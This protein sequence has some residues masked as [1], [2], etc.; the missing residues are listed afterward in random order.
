MSIEGLRGA[1][2][3]EPLWVDDIVQAAREY[4]PRLVEALERAETGSAEQR[5][6]EDGVAAARRLARNR[7]GYLETSRGAMA[8][9]FYLPRALLVATGTKVPTGARRRP[10]FV[11]SK[12]LIVSM[13]DLA[14]HGS[15]CL[16][17]SPRRGGDVKVDVAVMKLDGAREVVTGRIFLRQNGVDEPFS[18]SA[19]GAKRVVYDPGTCGIARVAAQFLVDGV[20]WVEIAFRGEPFIPESR[21]S[22]DAM[23]FTRE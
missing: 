15:I 2:S 10:P 23:L 11:K 7:A 18:L 6:L 22:I 20:F 3:A 9:R 5:V 17:L 16:D 4:L 13:P 19:T 1:V 14:A 21:P 8:A 12:G